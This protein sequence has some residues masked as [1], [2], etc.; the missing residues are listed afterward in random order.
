MAKIWLLWEWLEG[1]VVE[2][3]V[4]LLACLE[5][6]GMWIPGTTPS[7]ARTHVGFLREDALVV[8]GDVLEM[9]RSLPIGVPVAFGG[10][11]V[12]YE[13]VSTSLHEDAVFIAIDA[14]EVGDDGDDR[15]LIITVLVD[16]GA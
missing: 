7:S 3:I 6:E 13:S 12:A 16:V 2:M 10:L 8:G 9:D 15:K 4:E 11:S 1:E 14:I 5:L